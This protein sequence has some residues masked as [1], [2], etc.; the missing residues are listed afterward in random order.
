MSNKFGYFFK[1]CARTKITTLSI[2]FRHSAAS[3]LAGE[4]G[5]SHL[6]EHLICKSFDDLTDMFTNECITWDAYTS[7]TM[8][9][10]TFHGLESKLT[11][12]LK[13]DLV[14]RITTASSLLTSEII[15]KEKQI[16]LQEVVTGYDDP[17][18][19]HCYNIWANHFGFIEAGGIPEEIKNMTLKQVKDY[20]KAHYTQPA[21]IVETGKA[22]TEFKKVTYNMVPPP[23]PTYKFNKKYKKN[24]CAVPETSNVYMY[25]MSKKLVK[26]TDI[27]VLSIALDVMFSE[28]HSP[29][30]QEL[31]EKRG[32]CYY[33]GANINSVGYPGI[34]TSVVVTSK[35][36]IDEVE[37][38]Y[39]DVVKNVRKYFTEERFNMMINQTAIA[40][41]IRDNMP[42]KNKGDLIAYD[43]PMLPKNLKSITYQKALGILEHYFYH[44][45]YFIK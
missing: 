30:Y 45:E 26:K 33:V 32:L 17:F 20:M 43:M 41:E 24:I 7:N 34:L 11:P 1:K 12:Q 38:I 14:K 42:T 29:F 16:V 3:E 5:I 23:T 6:C 35:E 15:E 28:L 44:L 18:N 19:G 8:V 39:K 10:F 40:R 37:K 25:V 36:N 27:P 2:V 13:Q 21:R 4:H 31:R 9:V 22:K